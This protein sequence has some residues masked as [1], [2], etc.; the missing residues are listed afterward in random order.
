MN[1]VV[2]ENGVIMASIL[3]ESKFELKKVSRSEYI[4]IITE[5]T[6]LEY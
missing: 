6:N 5:M 3:V 4:E 2:G 1:P